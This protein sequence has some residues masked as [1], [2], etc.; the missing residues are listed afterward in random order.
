MAH[1]II[2]YMCIYYIRILY[3]R[4]TTSV[5]QAAGKEKRQGDE[6]DRC[7]NP[8]TLFDATVRERGQ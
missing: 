1:I 3:D 2:I 7:N 5:K 8:A 6:V 4:V